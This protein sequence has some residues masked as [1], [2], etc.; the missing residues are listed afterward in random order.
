MISST[1]GDDLWINVNDTYWNWSYCTLLKT[2]A[3]MKK[4]RTCRYTIIEQNT[5]D[6]PKCSENCSKIPQIGLLDYSAIKNHSKSNQDNTNH[7][8]PGWGIKRDVRDSG[9]KPCPEQHWGR[10]IIELEDCSYMS[11]C[12]MSIGKS[13]Y[14]LFLH[15]INMLPCHLIQLSIISRNRCLV[16]SYFLAEICKSTFKLV[17]DYV[18]QLFCR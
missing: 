10:N 6:K 16:I 17:H 15:S 3:P 13:S 11:E 5:C 12:V 2:C 8:C 4:V 7:T 18:Q 14:Q 9:I 1:P